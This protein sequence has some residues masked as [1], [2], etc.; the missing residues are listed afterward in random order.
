MR[1]LLFGEE[2]AEF[3]PGGIAITQ[4]SFTRW[5]LYYAAFM[6]GKQ[7]SRQAGKQEA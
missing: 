2:F 4:H 3:L 1:E 6:P 7:A 5:A